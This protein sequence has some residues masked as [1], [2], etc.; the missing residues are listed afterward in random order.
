VPVDPLTILISVAAERLSGLRET[1]EPFWQAMAL[2]RQQNLAP[3]SRL[4]AAS[5]PPSQRRRELEDDIPRFPPY[6]GI[7]LALEPDAVFA[8]AR[9]RV[10]F[11]FKL[12]VAISTVL[13]F[14]LLGGIA[15]AIIG[16]LLGH[17][18]WAAVFGA[19]SAADMLGVIVYR[20]LAQIDG[21]IVSA[22]RLDLLFLST[23]ERL[24]DCRRQSELKEQIA[25]ATRV[26]QEMHAQ[27]A[28]LS[29]P[30]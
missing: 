11:V 1:S 19:V 30:A 6:M 18:V 8:D 23:R 17:A 12:T 7:A 28:A 24:R 5:P 27:L 4:R 9:R 22:Q 21:A 29:S 16:A 2:G 13:A 26:W 20:P 14:L 15:G 25:C 10:S 3:P